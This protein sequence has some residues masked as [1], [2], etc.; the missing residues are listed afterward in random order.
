MP[1]GPGATP[2]RRCDED[3]VRFDSSKTSRVRP[4]ALAFDC[5]DGAAVGELSD[6]EDPTCE[7]CDRPIPE[8]I[9]R[10][11]LVPSPIIRLAPDHPGNTGQWRLAGR[12]CGS[13]STSSRSESVPR[14]PP[15][16]GRGAARAA[17]E[18]YKR[19]RSL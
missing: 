7:W 18:T 4:Q 11:Q 2:K 12:G 17:G 13:R 15:R 10:Y 16:L 8:G 19:R 5:L 1:K 3:V 9:G 14:V 6:D